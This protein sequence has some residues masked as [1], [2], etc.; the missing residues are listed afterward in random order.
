MPNDQFRQQIETMRKENPG[1]KIDD[2][3]KI[4]KP[5]DL[6]L[7]HVVNGEETFERYYHLNPGDVISIY[8]G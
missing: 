2:D 6:A 1:Y 7:I 4:T 8:R 5:C 3:F